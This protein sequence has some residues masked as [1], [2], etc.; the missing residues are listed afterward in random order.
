MP[1]KKKSLIF[2]ETMIVFYSTEF[3]LKGKIGVGVTLLTGIRK[4]SG[5]NLGWDRN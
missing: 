4:G 1:R 5:L 2:V 3:V